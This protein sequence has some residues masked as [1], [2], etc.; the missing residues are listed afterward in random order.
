LSLRYEKRKISIVAKQINQDLSEEQK[1]VL[2]N[3][4][5]ETPYSGK[6]L[7]HS[8]DG[9]YACANCGQVLFTSRDKFPAPPPNDGWP[10]FSALAEKGVVEL[11][12]DFSY[13]MVRSEAVC[14]N[15]RAHLGHYFEDGPKEAG[16][17]HY[18]INSVCLDFKKESKT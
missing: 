5:T 1:A 10:S 14:S 8:E 15:C 17:A 7:N 11:K 6:Y 2:F 18:C 16:G 3:N 4:A 9:E 13:G 12:T